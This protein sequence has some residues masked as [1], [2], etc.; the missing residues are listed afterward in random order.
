MPY[1]K[2]RVQQLHN[3]KKYIYVH[4]DG[5]LRGVLPLLGET[6]VDCAQSVTPAPVGDIPVEK[7]REMAGPNIILWGG[8][9][10]I[11]FSCQYSEK[12]LRQ[13]AM[14]IIKHHL[15]GHKFIMGVADQVPPDGDIKRV[16]MITNLVERY[17][18]YY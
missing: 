6:G 13:M 1:Y 17:A 9:P 7:L 3:A 18:R 11:Y 16:K 10:G 14:D 5:T 12:T 4:I 2:K 8:L 15:E